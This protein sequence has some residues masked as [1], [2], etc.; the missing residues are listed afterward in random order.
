MPYCPKCDME[1]VE[2]ITKCTDCGGPLVESKEVAEE[3]MRKAATAR[4]E[5]MRRYYEKM[6]E[7]ATKAQQEMPSETAAKAGRQAAS[8]STYVNKGQRYDDLNSSAA[9]FFI[10]GGAAALILALTFTGIINLPFTG[11]MRYMFLGMLA[12]MAV[13]SFIIALSSKKAA[14][15]LKTQAASEEKKTEEII[16]WFIGKHTAKDIDR[17][18][19]SVERSLGE[20]EMSLRRFDL[21]QDYL[22]TGKDLTDQSYIDMLCDEIY[23]RLYENK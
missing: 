3:L 12:F 6:M 8:S 10:V 2:G 16:Q 18:I 11:V 5:Q 15:V 9:A 17:Q 23:S 13:G 4:N 1:F 7:E 14:G 20:E 21:I 19:L 22:I